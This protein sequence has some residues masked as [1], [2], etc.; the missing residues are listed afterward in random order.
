ME[1]LLLLGNKRL[2]LPE[3]LLLLLR[4]LGKVVKGR[5]R[6]SQCELLAILV[7]KHSL[8]GFWSALLNRWWLRSG[9]WPGLLDRRLLWSGFWPGLW[10]GFWSCLLLSGPFWFYKSWVVVLGRKLV[11]RWFPLRCRC[12][13][14]LGKVPEGCKRRCLRLLLARPNVN[15][16]LSGSLGLGRRRWLGL[17]LSGPLLGRWRTLL[18]FLLWRW[19]TSPRSV[20]FH[21]RFIRY[22]TFG[23]L[24]TG[25]SWAGEIIILGTQLFPNWEK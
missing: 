1:L 13:G 20:V 25:P 10:S 19:H 22:Q 9:L 6:G 21:R 2:L 18:N 24:R 15:V 7:A 5:E 3:R 11:D 12:S 17:G 14:K 8:D 4:R 16:G 23:N